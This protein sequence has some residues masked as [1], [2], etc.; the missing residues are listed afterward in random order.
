VVSHRIP[1]TFS[2]KFARKCL[3]KKNQSIKIRTQIGVHEKCL[4][5]AQDNMEAAAAVWENENP[6]CTKYILRGSQLCFCS[7]GN[8]SSRCLHRRLTS[9]GAI[10]QLLSII[11]KLR[12]VVLLPVST[13]PY[14]VVVKNDS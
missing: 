8:N 5:H 14:V 13:M 3:K 7:R 4:T 1:A 6:G 2:E 10:H 12:I 11:L 9:W